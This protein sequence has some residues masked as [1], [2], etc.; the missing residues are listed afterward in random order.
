M[1]T[2]I[3]LSRYLF[4]RTH[5]PL[6]YALCCTVPCLCGFSVLLA[7]EWLVDEPW[8]ANTAFE[9]FKVTGLYC[10]LTIAYKTATLW[11][12]ERRGHFALECLGVCFLATIANVVPI[13][14]YILIETNR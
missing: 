5:H 8:V 13:W 11:L 14:I 7:Y 3:N 6:V 2:I 12:A 10:S 4:P 1:K 9:A